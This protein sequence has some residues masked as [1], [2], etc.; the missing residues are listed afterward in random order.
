ME[1]L[2][3]Q[4]AEDMVGVLDN[5]GTRT[6]EVSPDKSIDQS[7][8]TTFFTGDVVRP[9]MNV[10][11]MYWYCFEYGRE[12]VYDLFTL[13]GERL[14][15]ALIRGC[16]YTGS[17]TY[18][19]LLE[20]YNKMI[21]Y[22]GEGKGVV[23]FKPYKEILPLVATGKSIVAAHIPDTEDHCMVLAHIWDA[24]GD[25]TLV[26]IH[27]SPDNDVQHSTVERMI[28]SLPDKG[29]NEQL[30]YGRE[31]AILLSRDGRPTLYGT[32]RKATVNKNVYTLQESPSFLAVGRYTEAFDGPLLYKADDDTNT[33]VNFSKALGV[34]LTVYIDDTRENEYVMKYMASQGTKMNH[35][36]APSNAMRPNDP[37]YIAHLW[38]VVNVVLPTTGPS[39]VWVETSSSSYLEC[40]LLKWPSTFFLVCSRSKTDMSKSLPRGVHRHNRVMIYTMRGPDKMQ[41]F[42]TKFGQPDDGV[43]T[44]KS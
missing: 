15:G 21:S 22:Y 12:H 14:V 31:R 23:M 9:S 17:S 3:V 20:S 25:N 33:T 34:K 30:Y 2:F 40:L 36:A 10:S 1:E 39:R 4:T 18:Y 27:Y 8:L 16:R 28:R 26:L 35:A 44:I 7:P 6:P 42:I 24:V 38:N 32:L 43:L 37:V 5:L 13:G 11:T 19:P 41:T 29:K